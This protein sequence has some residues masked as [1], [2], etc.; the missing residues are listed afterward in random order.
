VDDHDALAGNNPHELQA[1]AGQ[2]GRDRSPRHRKSPEEAD[3]PKPKPEVAV[4]QTDLGQVEPDPSRAAPPRQGRVEPQRV[5]GSLEPH[6][7]QHVDVVG[8]LVQP[9]LHQ[10]EAEREVESIPADQRRGEVR[11]HV[12]SISSVPDPDPERAGLGFG[13]GTGL[14]RR[15]GTGI[16][17]G[18][19]E[20]CERTA[21]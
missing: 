16:G 7:P 5:V 18:L 11:V 6:F 21:P 13:S 4:A 15:F 19:V 17:I 3:S 10:G 12:V 1:Q 9:L 8:Q 2:E 20:V 14:G